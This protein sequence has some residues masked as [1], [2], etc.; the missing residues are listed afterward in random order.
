[1][2]AVAV[3]IVLVGALFVIGGRE[4]E[5]EKTSKSESSAVDIGTPKESLG[6]FASPSESPAESGV[7]SG[8]QT[9]PAQKKQA[10]LQQ[11]PHAFTGFI[12]QYSKDRNYARRYDALSRERS[13]ESAIFR[14]SRFYGGSRKERVSHLSVHH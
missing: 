9:V 1:M 10:T 11:T 6:D 4:R 7:G 12:F 14:L 2:T 5:D 13:R 8:T 3:L